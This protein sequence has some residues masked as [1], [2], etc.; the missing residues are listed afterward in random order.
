V[1]SV[2]VGDLQGDVAPT[3]C[4]T[5][6]I[7]GRGMVFLQKKQAVSQAKGRSTPPGLFGEA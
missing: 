7:D 2:D 6:R 4:L 1:D 5:N 3:Q